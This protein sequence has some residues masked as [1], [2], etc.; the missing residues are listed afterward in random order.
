M[1]D[2]FEIYETANHEAVA[3]LAQ[4]ALQLGWYVT[5]SCPERFTARRE[6]PG[7][8]ELVSVAI[9]GGELVATH[10]TT[11]AVRDHL[12]CTR[13]MDWLCARPGEVLA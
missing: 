5:Q 13:A 8:D 4:H 9:I 1:S 10:L 3:V 6:E 2:T 7:F 12:T 11:S